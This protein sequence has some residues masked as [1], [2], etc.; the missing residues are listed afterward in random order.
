MT[1]TDNTPKA[2]K[3]PTHHVYHV[4]NIEGKKGGFWTKIGSAWT[5][6]DGKG[7]NVQVDTF[8]LNGRLVLRVVSEKKEG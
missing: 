6:E 8:P 4:R 1:D 2:S 3:S 5:N 7:F